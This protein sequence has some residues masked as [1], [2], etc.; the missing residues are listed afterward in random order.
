MWGEG[1]VK[2]FET[3]GDQLFVKHSLLLGL[4]IF[5]WAFFAVFFAC[6]GF[7]LGW[8]RY[9]NPVILASFNNL[10]MIIANT[11][12]QAKGKEEKFSYDKLKGDQDYSKGNREPLI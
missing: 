1:I 9:D 10:K 7:Y 2:F 8:R 3:H 11:K 4:H 6:I 5:F 12:R